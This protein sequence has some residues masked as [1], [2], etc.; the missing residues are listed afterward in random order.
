MLKHLERETFV[1]IQSQLFPRLSCI[2]VCISW[3]TLGAHF[4]RSETMDWTS[5]Q[6]LVILANVSL[7]ELNHFILFPKQIA[8]LEKEK[9]E[10]DEAKK[11]QIK[12][13]FGLIH[14][15]SMVI[16]FGSMILNEILCNAY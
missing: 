10:Q 1:S 16:Y 9:E 3:L 5:W 11:K 15:S 7:S 14:G 6:T 4:F 13:K 8:L 2:H 12:K